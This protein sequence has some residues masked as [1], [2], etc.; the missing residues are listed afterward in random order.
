MRVIKIW[1]SKVDKPNFT[2][3]GVSKKDYNLIDDTIRLDEDEVNINDP[4]ELCKYIDKYFF[5]YNKDKT[6][7]YNYSNTYK[8]VTQYHHLAYPDII[9][10]DDKY[11]MILDTEFMEVTL[12]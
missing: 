2:E 5:T 12:Y 7:K 10:I 8:N 6:K 11:Y 4:V 9:Q 3:N 1:R